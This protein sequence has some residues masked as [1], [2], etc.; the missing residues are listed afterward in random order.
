M[1]LF[2]KYEAKIKASEKTNSDLKRPNQS[3]VTE[4]E[5]L[6]HNVDDINNKID[7]LFNIVYG[8]YNMNSNIQHFYEISFTS[9]PPLIKFLIILNFQ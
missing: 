6:I 5:R 4:V 8:N 2:E 1:E 3:L 9:G 7:I